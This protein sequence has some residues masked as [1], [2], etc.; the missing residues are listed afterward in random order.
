MIA[1][2]QDALEGHKNITSGF[3]RKPEVAIFP[4]TA[5]PSPTEAAGSCAWPLLASENNT[6]PT[7]AQLW[8]V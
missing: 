2:P 3:Q 7:R 6:D 8:Q 5:I 1:G 4:L